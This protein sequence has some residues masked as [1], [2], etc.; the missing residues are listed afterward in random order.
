MGLGQTMLSVA[1][2]VLLT[3]AAMNA[4]KMIVDRD[5]DFYE[6]EAYK[7]AAI[8]ANSLLSEIVTK[9][10]DEYAS[11]SDA[12]YASVS[13]FSTS[14]GSGYSYYVNPGGAPDNTTPYRSVSSTYFNDIDDYDLYTR[15]ATS[16]DLTGFL[17]SV[18]VFYV[19]STD[20]E[21]PAPGPT[22]FKKIIVTVTNTN[23]IQKRDINGDGVEDN[24]QLKFS[25]VK[26]Y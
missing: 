8:L 23:Y 24:I 10:F 16:G 9:D 25:T 26:A 12:G 4:N 11:S 7:Q 5:R 14:M 18:S 3:I 20:L 21:T 15:T 13:S 19:S 6:Q 22:Y 17:L 1:F 2:L